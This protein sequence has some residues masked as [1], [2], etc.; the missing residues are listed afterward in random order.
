MG[1]L[2]AIR[3]K[4][5]A[6]AG[7]GKNQARTYLLVGVALLLGGL[8]YLDQSGGPA[9][10]AASRS[11]DSPAASGSAAGARKRAGNDLQSRLE[12]MRQVVAQRPEIEGR[13]QKIGFAYAESMASLIGYNEDGKVDD[14]SLRAAI[15]RVLPESVKLEELLV[16]A[17]SPGRGGSQ[18]VPLNVSLS[19]TDSQA[20]LAVVMQLGDAASGSLWQDLSIKADPERRE[21]RLDGTLS[22]LVMGPAE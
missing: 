3:G 21:V 22:L 13:Y 4:L 12:E 19:S 17:S 14:E 7:A 18:I 16:G 6:G 10:H 2:V 20:L 9:D 1:W 5:Q 11:D 8:I 15:S